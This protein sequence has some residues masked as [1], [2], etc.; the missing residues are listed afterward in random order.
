MTERVIAL[1]IGGTFIKSG[2]FV[3]G[4]LADTAK[5]PTRAQSLQTIQSAVAQAVEYWKDV[6]ADGIA[7][8]SA[9]DI[10]PYRGRCVYAT[11][12]LKGYSGFDIKSWLEERY[13]VRASALNDGHAALLGEACRRELTMPAVMLTLGT[14]VGGAY[15]DGKE[16][17]FGEDYRYGRFGHLVMCP[18]GKKCNCGQRGCIEQYISASALKEKCAAA[19][20]VPEKVFSNGDARSRAV[21]DEWIDDLCRAMETIYRVQKYELMIF[22]GGVCGS[23]QRWMPLLK[24]KTSRRVEISVLLNTAGMEGAYRWWCKNGKI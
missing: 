16:V 15:F 20:T 12:N 9:G 18:N 6:Q 11:D 24:Q 23:A 14:G 19:G 5:F 4:K 13:G 22:G 8:S 1:D 7:V 17:V 21:V 2:I 10:D 3:G